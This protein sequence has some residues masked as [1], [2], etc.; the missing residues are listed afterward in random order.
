MTQATGQPA[1][2]LR[3]QGEHVFIPTFDDGVR[4]LFMMENDR[5]V[6]VTLHHGGREIP[7]TRKP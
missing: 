2:A 3:N 7:G 6:S 5:A 1:F 4:L